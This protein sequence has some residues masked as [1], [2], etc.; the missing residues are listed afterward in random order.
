MNATTEYKRMNCA[1]CDGESGTEHIFREMNLGTRDEFVYWECSACGC[2]QIVSIPAN[3]SDYYPDDYYSF[4]MHATTFETWLYRAYFRAPRLGQLIRRA[5]VTFQ[6]VIDA[7]PKRGAQILDVGC[8]AGKMVNILRSMDFDAHGIDP[9]AKAETPHVRRAHLNEAAD[10]WDLIMFHHSL[11]HMTDNLGVL[12]CA[13][14]KLAP[15]G[16][17]LVRIPVANWAWHHYGKN[18]V[19]LDAPR[20]LVIH[21]PKSFLRVSE[22]AGFQA[23]RVTFDSMASQ[24][25]GSELYAR[26]IPLK[27]K[28]SA[29][30]KLTK[31]MMRRFSARAADLNRKKLGDQASFFLEATRS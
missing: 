11:E 15:G 9:F 5:G 24:F 21:T 13:R 12:R 18:W 28:H 23:S 26:D 10:G 20:H 29:T 31:A 19:Q 17:C 16:T 2:L 14:Q 27:E 6:S 1:V 8:G 4:S 22:L 30:A 25:Y 7:K 3:L